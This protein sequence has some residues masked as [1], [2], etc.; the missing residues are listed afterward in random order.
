MASPADKRRIMAR[1]NGRLPFITSDTRARLPIKGEAL[2]LKPERDC[3]DWIGEADLPT[4]RLIRIDQG[5]KHVEPV[6][7]G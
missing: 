6:A 2:L 7:V 1:V 3:R 5:G 4:L